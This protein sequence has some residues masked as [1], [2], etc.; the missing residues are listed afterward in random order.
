MANKNLRDFR[1]AVSVLKRKGLISRSIDARS[2]KPTP[3]LQKSLIKFKRVLTGEAV[4]VKLSPSETRKKKQQGY[5]ISQ[6]K[7]QPRKVIIPVSSGDKVTVS[8]GRLTTRLATGLKT[9]DIEPDVSNVSELEKWVAENTKRLNAMKRKGEF[10]GFKLKGYSST[11]IYT[12]VAQLFDDLLGYD[13]FTEYAIKGEDET[14]NAIES[15]QIVSIH[16]RGDWRFGGHLAKPKGFGGTSQYAKIMQKFNRSPKVIKTRIRHARAESAKAQ[17]AK[18]KQDPAKYEAYKA[19]A[20][21][22]AA[23]SKKKRKPA[24]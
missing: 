15:V 14:R 21:E 9:V 19:A 7:G 11:Q 5:K 1:H 13:I 16:R 10:F 4:A 6:A 20:R 17:R 18:L 2:V 22:R 12:N 8:H 3:A 23:K 24:K